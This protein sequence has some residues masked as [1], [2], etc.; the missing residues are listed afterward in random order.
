M[1]SELSL[2]AKETRYSLLKTVSDIFENNDQN[3]SYYLDLQKVKTLHPDGT[4]YFLHHLDKYPRV[5]IRGR[6]SDDPIVKAML[7]KLKVHQRM[8]LAECTKVHPMIDKWHIFIGEKAEFDDSYLA[9]EEMLKGTLGNSELF[10]RLNEAIS[11]AVTNAVSHGYS[12]D[13]TYKRW[14]LFLAI[15]Q[16]ICYVVISD[17]GVTIPKSAPMKLTEKMAETLKFWSNKDDAE[18]IKIATTW[19][20]TSTNKSYRG[21]GFDN[22]LSVCEQHKSASILVLSRNGAWSSQD[23]MASYTRPVKGTIIS[24]RIP[25]AS[26]SNETELPA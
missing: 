25:L 20:K 15:S 7:T 13:A 21:K 22:I 11:E 5:V 19:R 3:N 14:V 10:Y 6:C 17:L 12:N 1:P 23:K 18:R 2:M 26:L 9:V 24:W 16:E 8:G 4:I